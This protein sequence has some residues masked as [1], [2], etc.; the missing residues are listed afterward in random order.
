MGDPDNPAPAVPTSANLSEQVTY[1]IG[2]RTTKTNEWGHLTEQTDALDRTMSIE[3]DEANRVTRIDLPG[4]DC[5]QAD[6]DEL[7]NVLSASRFP[8][9][10][11][12]TYSPDLQTAQTS[13]R[14]YEP[15]FNQPKTMIAP[16]G[17]QVVYYYDYELGQGDAGRV[18]RIDYPSIHN[19]HGVLTTPSV[20]LHLQQ[21]G[22]NR[23]GNR[24]A[25]HC[26]PIFIHTRHT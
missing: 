9:V 17:E 3:R 24:C 18:A 4:G 15:R 22:I 6:Y 8:A 2:G 19:E 5:I 20:F 23:N 26:D 21:H 12:A 13:A 10:E 25:R 7:G 11:C 14:T 1:G 16:S